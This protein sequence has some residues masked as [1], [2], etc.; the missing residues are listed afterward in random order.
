MIIENGAIEFKIKEGG[1]IDP[2]TGF[3]RKA[4]TRWGGPIP[5]QYV[6]NGSSLRGRVNGEGFTSA[7]YVILVEMQP[8]PDSEQ[9]RLTDI[10]GETVGE[11]SLLSLPEL[12]PAVDQI[13]LTV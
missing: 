8:L 11:Y 10:F 1:G 2:A 5:C 3:P 12:L 13:R 6:P 7:S 4:E 9:V